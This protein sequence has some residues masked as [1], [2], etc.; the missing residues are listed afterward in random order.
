VTCRLELLW[1][2]PFVM[3]SVTV[4]VPELA[5]LFEGFCPV[6][7]LLSPNVHPQLTGAGDPV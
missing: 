3:V 6:S 4:Y 2:V 7:V 5:Y 1:H